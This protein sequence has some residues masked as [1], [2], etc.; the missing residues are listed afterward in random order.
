MARGTVG[1]RVV[2]LSLVVVGTL[3]VLLVALTL[4]LQTS[5]VSRRVLEVVVPRASEA[6]G[7]QVTVRDARL[8]LFPGPRVDLAGAAVAG[9]AGEPP[10]VE[11]DALEVSLEPWP[12]VTSLGKDVRVKGIHLVKPVVNLVRAADG[13]WNYQ[14]LGGGDAAP[15]RQPE[16]SPPSDRRWVVARAT[17]DDGSVRL[18]D[19]SGG[20]GEAAVAISRIR[21]AADHVG[22]GEPL[23]ARLSAAVAGD[24][25]NFEAQLHV[26]RLPASVAELGPGR[27]PELTGQLA[28][29]ALDLARLRAFLP[30]GVTGVMTGGRLD[31]E[32]KLTT[33]AQR[34]HVDGGGKLSQVRLRGEP[35]QGSFE[36]HA[37]AD[38]AAGTARATLDKLALKGPG[39]DLGGHA[40]VDTR[41]QRVRFAIAGPL[42][43]LGQVMGLLPPQEEKKQGGFALSAAQR[44]AVEALDVAGT[45][46]IDKVVKGAF[47]AS[48]LKANAVLEQGVFV[49]RDAQAGFFG[50]R[51]DAS[52]TRFDVAPAQPTWTLKAKLQG[53]DLGQAMTALSGAAPVMG[54]LSGGLDLDG[55]GVEWDSLRRALTGQGAIE[56]Q[57]GAL[58][59]TDVGDQVLGAVAKGLRAIGRGGA[60]GAVSGVTGKT[61]LRDLAAQFTVKDGAMALSKPL[62]FDA[63]FGAATLGGRIGLDGQ[64]ALQGTARVSKQALA[65]VVGSGVPLPDSLPV[66][67]TLGGSL[68]HPSVSVDAQEA[69]AGLV[70]GAAKR[71]AQELQNRAQDEAKR[72]ARRGLG[73]LLKG[74]G[75]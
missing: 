36:L 11:L 25:P 51:V 20:G 15:E 32:A 53:V 72:A 70:G 10:L 16:A 40:A 8:R 45:I 67:L 41:P 68:T 12:L 33:E 55:A 23:E 52:G 38:P 74:L 21:F 61:T 4:L 57:E 2:K 42:L 35:A 27:Y 31:A 46:A 60:A 3:V 14:G 44:R 9:R 58:T 73:D 6:L 26:S 65:G 19:R 59:T 54:K 71:G 18:V 13:S 30:P 17:V 69:V 62:A 56:L 50:G 28:L 43:D 5:A 37:V 29:K 48:D 75:Q 7:R 24:Q 1:R 47:T 63:P 34:Y 39:V 22:L 64:L 66:P 49:L